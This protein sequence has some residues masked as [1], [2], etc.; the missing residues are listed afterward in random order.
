MS[1]CLL[2]KCSCQFVSYF[3]AGRLA[4]L[5]TDYCEILQNGRNWG[6]R[7][8]AQD[9]APDETVSCFLCFAWKQAP[10]RVLGTQSPI[11]LFLMEPERIFV[12]SSFEKIEQKPQLFFV[13]WRRNG[14]GRI[15]FVFGQ[16][17]KN[18]VSMIEINTFEPFSF[19]E[20]ASGFLSVSPLVVVQCIEDRGTS[21]LRDSSV[22]DLYLPLNTLYENI[23]SFKKHYKQLTRSSNIILRKCNLRRLQGRRVSSSKQT[24]TISLPPIVSYCN[25]GW[26]TAVNKV[27]KHSSSSTLL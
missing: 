1:F 5:E 9:L 6:A 27:L 25:C 3:L 12:E 17:F 15:G 4:P 13:A 8:I 10:A 19:S 20:G 2:L 11:E 24:S 26:W 22:D 16:L 21:W 23:T 18:N 7:L 14:F